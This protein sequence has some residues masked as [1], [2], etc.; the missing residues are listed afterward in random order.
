MNLHAASWKEPILE[1]VFWLLVLLSAG[2]VG[3]GFVNAWFVFILVGVIALLV[4]LYGGF[5]EPR[6]VRVTKYRLANTSTSESQK[7]LRIV[8]LSDLHAGMRK[9][10]GFYKMVADRVAALNPD[11]VILGGDLVNERTKDVEQI[12]SIL[13]LKSPLGVWFILGNHDFLDDP[14]ELVKYVLKRG[15][16]NL[17]NQSLTFNVGDGRPLEIIGL[18]DSW[19]G[20]PDMSLLE[21]PRQG[22][23]LLVTHEPDLLL[24]LP[25]NCADMILLGHT[26]GGQIRLPGYGS[27]MVLPQSVP[28]SYDQ[29][30]KIW[31]NMRVIISRGLAETLVRARLG[32][33]PEIVLLEVG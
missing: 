24:D 14:K 13:Q 11:M 12:A 6:L 33:R 22:V 2:L 4:F 25:E 15:A 29:G 19:Y 8:F 5:V 32:V 21:R 27:V 18:D 30:E 20:S 23:R 28:Q 31:R 9:Q 16:R 17:T 1:G 3:V 7:T 26:H 10:A